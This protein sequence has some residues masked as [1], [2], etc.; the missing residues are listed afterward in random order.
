MSITIA[1]VSVVTVAAAAIYAVVF[2]PFKKKVVAPSVAP[3]TVEPS[4]NSNSNV[5]PN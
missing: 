3:V 4:K 2:N 5:K 1:I